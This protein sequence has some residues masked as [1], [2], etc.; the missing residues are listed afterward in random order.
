MIPIHS[1]DQFQRFDGWLSD[2]KST[3]GFKVATSH[4]KVQ[5]PNDDS[6]SWE[7]HHVHKSEVS[8]MKQTY[9]S[10]DLTAPIRCSYIALCTDE[11]V[12][13][14]DE[15]IE[16]DYLVDLEPCQTFHDD[17]QQLHT[18][19]IAQQELVLENLE[20]GQIEEALGIKGHGYDT[21]MEQI[22]YDGRYLYRL[23]W[24][25]GAELSDDILVGAGA[26]SVNSARTL[27][28]MKVAC[29]SL[30]A[31]QDWSS[32][33]MPVTNATLLVY[34]SPDDDTIW[35]MTPPSGFMSLNTMALL[36]SGEDGMD[37][38][39]EEL[40]LTLDFALDAA[41]VVGRW[42][43][44]AAVDALELPRAM[45]AL[46]TVNL[47]NLHPSERSLTPIALN[48]EKA[49]IWLMGR[50]RICDKPIQCLDFRTLFNDLLMRRTCMSV[51]QVEV[52]KNKTLGEPIPHLHIEDAMNAAVMHV[53]KKE[54]AR[55]KRHAGLVTRN[56]KSA[57]EAHAAHAAKVNGRRTRR[58]G[59]HGQ[60]VVV[61]QLETSAD[62]SGQKVA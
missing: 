17:Q 21:S 28:S 22:Y 39:D 50:S 4:N 14:S 51:R 7:W 56:R 43:G 62:S 24:T 48:F 13:N 57:Q 26:R 3:L 20:N 40:T 44:A 19:W 35:G 54:K 49:I 33:I 45:I 58:R 37:K 47:S 18:M 6:V 36:S 23:P 41:R 46:Q 29:V 5:A 61:K 55:Q 34:R 11:H 10:P 60:E 25:L 9:S 53:A 42:C 12:P 31:N 8:R 2:A 27:W 15:I 1:L 16:N 59:N 38:L 32:L 52:R 30:S